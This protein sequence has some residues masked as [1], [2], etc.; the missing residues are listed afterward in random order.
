MV[1]LLLLSYVVSI[2]M[3]KLT[4][5]CIINFL[6]GQVMDSFGLELIVYVKKLSICNLLFCIYD[7]FPFQ[8]LEDI[9]Y[10]RYIPSLLQFILEPGK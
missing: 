5:L 7:T 9:V 2:T 3:L 1:L 8:D 6:H 10:L 4:E